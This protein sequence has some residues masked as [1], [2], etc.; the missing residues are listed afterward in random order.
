MDLDV[1]HKLRVQVYLGSDMAAARIEVRGS[2]TPRNVVALYVITRRTNA[3]AP[4]M[5]VL[6]DLS[7][8]RVDASVLDELFRAARNQQLP[9]GVDP[10]PAPC[11]LRILEPAS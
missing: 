1:H 2:V 8:A 7:R 9:A 3:F 4:G 5:E 11:C 6:L 10:S